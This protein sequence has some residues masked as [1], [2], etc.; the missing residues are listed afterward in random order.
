[1][2]LGRTCQK[3]GV[4]PEELAI[5][6]INS[7]GQ[8]S[9][10]SNAHKLHI[11]EIGIIITPLDLFI[12][13]IIKLCGVY[14]KMKKRRRKH[15]HYSVSCHTRAAQKLQFSP[16]GTSLAQATTN[17]STIGSNT[18]DCSFYPFQLTN[19]DN[20][21]WKPSSRKC[22]LCGSQVFIACF[23]GTLMGIQY[24]SCE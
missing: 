3:S 12:N 20:S 22:W 23:L 13:A 5:T 17:G 19:V 2:N 11:C 6:C 14:R 8:H 9:K 21:Y 4:Y 15:P 18:E 7:Y 1:M 24:F 16:Y 10:E